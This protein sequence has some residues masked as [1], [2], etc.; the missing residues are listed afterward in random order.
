M[1]TRKRA[2]KDLC[3]S[4]ETPEVTTFIPKYRATKKFYFEYSLTKDGKYK[5]KT[6][7]ISFEDNTTSQSRISL[8]YEKSHEIM[9]LH[10]FSFKPYKI[11]QEGYA[12]EYL[13]KKDRKV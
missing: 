8:N 1:Q 12:I 13:R 6:D 10:Q 2:F 9:T 5:P 4:E 3:F 7:F 11:V